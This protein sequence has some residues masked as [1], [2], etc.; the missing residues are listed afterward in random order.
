MINV[1]VTARFYSPYEITLTDRGEA[2]YLE[3][4][5]KRAIVRIKNQPRSWKGKRSIKRI[6][7]EVD[8]LK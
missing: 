7:F 3:L 4:A 8:V 1:Q 5:I 6:V 2:S